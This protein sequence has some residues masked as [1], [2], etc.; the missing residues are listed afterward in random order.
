M[1]HAACMQIVL[2]SKG[3][4]TKVPLFC[5]FMFKQCISS[6]SNWDGISQ[7]DYKYKK[8]YKKN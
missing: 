4:T 5:A 1:L 3:G 2:I 7:V 6:Y 8:N